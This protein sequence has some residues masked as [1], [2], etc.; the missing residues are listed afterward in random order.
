MTDGFAV[1]RGVATTPKM[2]RRVNAAVVLD[3]LRDTEALSAADLVAVTGLSRPTVNAVVDGPRQP[4]DSPSSARAARRPNRRALA[5]GDAASRSAPI[6]DMWLASTSRVQSARS[7]RRPAA[8]SLPSAG[9]AWR[10]RPRAALSA[11]R[12]SAGP[13]RRRCAPR[14]HD[15]ATSLAVGA[16]FTGA[17]DTAS[18]TVLS[19]GAFSAGFNVA[20]AL[21]R[22][23]DAPVL[24]DN[25]GSRLR[26]ATS[27]RL[28][29]ASTRAA[30]DG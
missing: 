12:R 3:A 14:A 7:S 25:E 1:A 11:S 19:S 6:T 27:E 16:R 29:A 8:T 18:G 4:G 30:W 5:A 23:L 28:Q 20:D 9:A 17:V 10:T 21:G 22:G 13:S 26:C 24:V 15:A 2:L